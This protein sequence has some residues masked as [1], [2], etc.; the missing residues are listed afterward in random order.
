MMS[1]MLRRLKRATL[2]GLGEAG[3]H[4]VHDLHFGVVE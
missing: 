1:I 4:V 2:L 3:K